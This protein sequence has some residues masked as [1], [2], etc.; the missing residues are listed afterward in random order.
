M[1]SLKYFFVTLTLAFTLSTSAPAGEMPGAGMAAAQLRTVEADGE[2]PGAGITAPATGII[3]I[4][5]ENI[6]SIL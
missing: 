6:L 2:M 1:K 4:I 3:L 5:V